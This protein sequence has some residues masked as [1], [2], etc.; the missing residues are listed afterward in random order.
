MVR[1]ASPQSR[2]ML[3]CLHHSTATSHWLRLP[4][5]LP[6]LQRVER[7]QSAAFTSKCN[8][9]SGAPVSS[10]PLS[11]LLLSGNTASLIPFRVL[12]DS[13]TSHC[14]LSPRA[15]RRL[16]FVFPDNPGG[17]GTMTVADGS[18]TLIY[19]WTTTVRVCPPSHLTSSSGSLPLATHLPFMQCLVADISEDVIIGF[20]YILPSHGQFF[21]DINQ[22]TMVLPT[23][24]YSR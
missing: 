2:L 5:K 4:T 24:R 8:A 6:H 17:H 11:V 23:V 21:E 9:I 14:V 18:S 10:F 16:G 19:S 7:V 22:G 12:W 1:S 3:S 20:D 15:A 13:G